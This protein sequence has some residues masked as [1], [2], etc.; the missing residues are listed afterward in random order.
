MCAWDWYRLRTNGTW[1]LSSDREAGNG[2]LGTLADVGHQ[3]D[4]EA[5]EGRLQHL[6][7]GAWAAGQWCRKNWP[8]YTSWQ[9][10]CLCVQTPLSLPPNNKNTCHYH[11]LQ[12]S[13]KQS[14]LSL[15]GDCM[16]CLFN[17]QTTNGRAG[18]SAGNGLAIGPSLLV[19]HVEYWC[20]GDNEM[21]MK[22]SKAWHHWSAVC[23]LRW[24]SW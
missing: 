13:L 10:T 9:Q 6:P 20:S 21:W 2:S 23:R 11:K 22:L 17:A 7:A 15:Y 14:T 18:F 12:D 3:M 24:L 8:C 19:I 16:Q 1:L 5:D 4:E